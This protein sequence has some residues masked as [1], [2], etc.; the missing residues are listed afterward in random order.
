MIEQIEGIIE[1]ISEKEGMKGNKAWKKTSYK[2]GEN[3]YSSFMKLGIN[4][5]DKV[6]F[7]FEADEKYG[8]TVKTAKL[9]SKSADVPADQKPPVKKDASVQMS[10]STGL[11]VAAELFKLNGVKNP[12]EAN[13]IMSADI[14]SNYILNGNKD[15]RESY[16]TV[17]I[18]EENHE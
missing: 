9:I 3:W 12:S 15:Q 5:G 1:A 16:E 10:R 7:E 8:A 13:L 11:Y 17:K 18:G 4:K 6:L 14:F 2:I